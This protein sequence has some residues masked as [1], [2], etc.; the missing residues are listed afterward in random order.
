MMRPARG[1][2]PV[3]QRLR[4][5]LAEL[6]DAR[7]GAACAGHPDEA[8]LMRYASGAAP[9]TE[10]MALATHFG[11]CETCCRRAAHLLH[12]HRQLSR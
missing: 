2:P 3:S 1:G 7:G 10:R 12:A 6:E 5:L 8:A 4:D 9:P 11:L